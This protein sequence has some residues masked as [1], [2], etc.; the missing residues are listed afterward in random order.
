MALSQNQLMSL[1]AIPK[2]EK[3][4]TNAWIMDGDTLTRE[5]VKSSQFGKFEGK[6]GSVVRNRKGATRRMPNG[7][8]YYVRPTDLEVVAY[9]A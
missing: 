8:R 2:G 3:R 1:L 9:L 5:T 4:K 7:R 6:A